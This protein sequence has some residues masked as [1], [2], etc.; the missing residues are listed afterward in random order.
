MPI[1]PLQRALAVALQHHH[2]GRLA[3]AETIYRQVLA[4]E[5]LN[6]DA[7]HLL[8]V[9][10][11]QAGRQDAAVDLLT[12]AIG[13]AP[14]VVNFHAILAEAYQALGHWDEAIAAYQ[15]AIALKPNYPEALNNLGNALKNKGHLDKAIAT[16]G[17]AIVLRPNYPEAHSNLGNALKDEGR[18][19][20]AI[21][22]YRRAIALRPNYPEA[23]SN[24]GDALRER[25]QFSEAVAASRRAI[26][27]RSDIPEFHINLGIAL[28]EQGHLDEA[29]AAYRQAVTLKPD[30]PETHVNLAFALLAQGD[31]LQGWEEYE[32]RCKI[33]ALETQRGFTRPQWDGGPLEGRALLL[34]TEQ[35]FGDAIQFIRYLPLAAENAGNIIIECQEEL[36][37]LFQRIAPDSQVIA[38]SQSLPEFEVQCPLLSL[39]RLF[40]TD[41]TNIPQSVPYLHPEAVGA[42]A[43]RDRMGGNGSSLKAGLVWAGSSVHKSLR[44]RSL[45]LTDLGP[46]AKIPRLQCYSLQK[47]DAAVG[48]APPFDLEITD[49]TAALND[50]ADT[51]AL[52]ANLD[53]VISVD[54]AVAHLAGALG[55][56][57]WTL[58]PFVPDWRWGLEDETTPWYPTMRLFR[59]PKL[60]DWDSVIQRVKEELELLVKSRSA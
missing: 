17:Q 38:K 10:A 59:Q 49:V 25:G 45:K 31:F 13:L 1:I 36:Q 34:H 60:G 53:L 46:I 12:K 57:V 33:K 50:F 48:Q 58:L 40:H 27:L 15:R 44:N 54:T 47:G 30:D 20:E 39:P 6:I 5:P 16:Y 43:F 11:H 22:A 3:E 35:G 26:A 55:K 23:H 42:E 2:A 37:R 24:L 52:I 41:Q 19:D 14:G 8:G 9:L 32:W 29:I 21:A 4:A 56:P 7:L 18:L 51:A 28:K